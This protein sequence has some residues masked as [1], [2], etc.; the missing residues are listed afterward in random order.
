MPSVFQALELLLARFEHF[1][2][3]II[4]QSNGALLTEC[5]APFVDKGLV[6]RPYQ[7]AQ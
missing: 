2:E 6:R 1:S 5:A 3:R 4:L 7:P